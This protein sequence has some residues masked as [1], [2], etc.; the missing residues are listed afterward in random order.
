MSSVVV[1]LKGRIMEKQVRAVLSARN[2]RW[3]PLR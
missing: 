2:E 3:I 1:T